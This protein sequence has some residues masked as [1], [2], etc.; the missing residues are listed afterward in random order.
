MEG[1][2][3]TLAMKPI[4]LVS[5]SLWNQVTN[6]SLKDQCFI[7]ELL[8]SNIFLWKCSSRPDV[9]VDLHEICA[10]VVVHVRLEVIP[11]FSFVLTCYKDRSPA[12]D[13]FAE[14]SKQAVPVLVPLQQDGVVVQEVSGKCVV[15]PM[16]KEYF[17]CYSVTV[18]TLGL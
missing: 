18:V 3:P 11:L 14:A 6:G 12:C 7:S 15:N 13:I 5:S 2:P 1:E 10:C 9:H 8:F 4:K 17:V 16:Q